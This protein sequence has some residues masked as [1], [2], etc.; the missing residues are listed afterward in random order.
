MAESESQSLTARI[1]QQDGD[2]E[3]GPNNLVYYN[4]TFIQRG[5]VV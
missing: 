4:Q 2:L 5:W 1:N 3:I